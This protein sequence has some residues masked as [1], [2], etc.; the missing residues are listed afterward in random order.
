MTIQ[1]CN[2]ALQPADSCISKTQEESH[3]DYCSSGFSTKS[4]L[5]VKSRRTKSD[6]KNIFHIQKYSKAETVR[7][8]NG[9][10]TKYP[11]RLNLSSR[12]DVLN[13]CSLR[14]LRRHFWMLFRDNSHF[15]SYRS[16]RVSFAKAFKAMKTLLTKNYDKEVFDDDM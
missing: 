1:D 16:D 9:K 13:K 12:S 5:T 4:S 8:L 10:Q 2:K 15:R 14:K 11:K 6:F 3:K 7:Q